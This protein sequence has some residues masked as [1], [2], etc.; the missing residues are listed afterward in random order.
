MNHLDKLIPLVTL[1]SVAA[2]LLFLLRRAARSKELTTW[3]ESV[4]VNPQP[5]PVVALPQEEIRVPVVPTAA[6]KRAARKKRTPTPAVEATSPTPIDA[7]LGL[8]KEKD[9]LV[10]AFLLREILGPPV[11][12]RQAR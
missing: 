2:F 11:S 4:P 8:L 5:V 9:A 7:A 6:E 3:Q 1:L 10:T 12:R